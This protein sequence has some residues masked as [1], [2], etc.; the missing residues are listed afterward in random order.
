MPGLYILLSWTFVVC[1]H[2][3][4]VVH[5]EFCCCMLYNLSKTTFL[6]GSYT[7]REFVISTRIY[8]PYDI[9]VHVP[10]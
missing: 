6:Y 9:I 4:I 1:T 3:S 8:N 10:L 7:F 2:L 5:P